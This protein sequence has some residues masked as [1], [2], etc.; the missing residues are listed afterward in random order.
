M[1]RPATGIAILALLFLYIFTAAPAGAEVKKDHMKAFMLSFLVPGLGQFY[2]GSPG[3]A[4]LFIATELAIWGGY[5]YNTTM[6]QARRQDYLAQGALKA[7]AD[8]SETGIAYL[9]AIGAYNSSFDY[10]QSQLQMND[11]PVLYTGNKGWNWDSEADRVQFRYLRE[12]ELDYENNIKYCIAGA[13]LNHFLSGL[14]AS[15]LIRK[16]SANR[17]VTVNVLENGLAL[18]Y[19]RSY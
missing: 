19:R 5:Y 7:G 13:V 14:Q 16:S 8:P 4:K 17:A 9:N 11:V 15:S 3:Y 12:R 18:T 10:N 2:A 1:K 6:K